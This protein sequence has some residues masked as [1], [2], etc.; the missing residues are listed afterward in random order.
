MAW[1][2]VTRAGIAVCFGLT[3]ILALPLF[4]KQWWD[5]KVLMDDLPQ[6]HPIGEFFHLW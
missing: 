5:L 6:S 3:W 4:F 1:Q 2:E